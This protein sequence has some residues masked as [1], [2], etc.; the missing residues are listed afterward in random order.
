MADHGEPSARQLTNGG[1]S[2]PTV[3]P[4]GWVVF[5]RGV[6]Q[7][8]PVSVWRVPIGG[9]A[10]S[11]ITEG[12][13]I[14]PVVSPDGRLVAHYWL[15]P[16]RWVLAVVPVGG[17]APERVFP[18]SITHCGRT[19]R[20]SP[21]S[22]ALAYIDCPDGVTNIWLRPLDGAPRRLTDFR[23]GAIDTFD[24]SRDGTQLAWITRHQ[25]SDVVLVE[26]PPG[27]PRS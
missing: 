20:W 24:W 2:R 17:G 26:L 6:I 4:D 14:R 12:T 22:K 11:Q 3:S 21:D 23:S 5:Q 18:L 9:G 8:A 10:A 15:T 25:V 19:V 1:D 16:E 27:A 13:T 7:S